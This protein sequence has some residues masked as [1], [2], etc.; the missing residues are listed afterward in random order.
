[1][2]SEHRRRLPQSLPEVAS[3]DLL[4]GRDGLRLPPRRDGYRRSRSHPDANRRSPIAASI[5]EESVGICVGGPPVGV[6]VG[7][8]VEV[9]V[10]VAPITTPN[11]VSGVER[12]AKRGIGALELDVVTVL[13]GAKCAVTVVVPSWGLP[14]ANATPTGM[15]AVSTAA[16]SELRTS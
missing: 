8:G 7:T 14:A 9:G 11:A 6:G 15:S 16:A 3:H 12:L 2:Q 10:G 5:P 13:I 4:L 1:M